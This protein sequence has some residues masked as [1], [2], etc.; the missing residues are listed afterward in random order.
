VSFT[1]FDH[2][3]FAQP[4]DGWVM[5]RT[6]LKSPH[7]VGFRRDERGAT[8]IEFAFVA[9]ALI[10]ALLSLV[11]LGMLG[12]MI[13][14]VDAAVFEAARRIR[15]G[16]DDAATTAQAFEDQVCSNLG[17]GLAKCRERMVISV[18]KF[19]QFSDA[20]AVAAAPPD[21]TFNKGAAGDIIIVKVNY[22]W[23]LLTPFLAQFE[24]EGPTS[25]IIP[26]RAAFKNEPFE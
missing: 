20:N 17:G 10:F 3:P 8:A 16:R 25:V 24:H 22:T 9:P 6:R 14:G 13:M 21:G 7:A 26:A 18:K 19:A 5:F 1:V 23:P 2:E 12:M 4:W 15:T 11:E